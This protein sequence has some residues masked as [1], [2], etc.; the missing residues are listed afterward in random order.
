MGQSD[1]G[2]A[3]VRRDEFEIIHP[4]RRR[5]LVTIMGFRRL[6]IANDGKA[7]CAT[8][9]LGT[10]PQPDVAAICSILM[11]VAVAPAFE[12]VNLLVG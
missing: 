10:F 6:G 8:L 2:R 7:G 12:Y 1:L 5:Q 9:T 4:D 11:P 3:F